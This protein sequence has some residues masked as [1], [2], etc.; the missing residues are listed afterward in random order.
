MF[1][2]G[3]LIAAQSVLRRMPVGEQVVEM[4]LDLVRACRPDEP[5]ARGAGASR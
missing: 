1:N 4:I 2:A 3:E 5:A